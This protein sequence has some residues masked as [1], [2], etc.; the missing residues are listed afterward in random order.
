MAE[1][2]DGQTASQVCKPLK[3]GEKERKESPVLEQ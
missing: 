2:L 3:T 1:I